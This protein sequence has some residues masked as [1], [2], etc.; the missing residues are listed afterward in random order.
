MND[1]CLK[2]FFTGILV[3]IILTCLLLFLSISLVHQEKPNST[4]IPTTPTLNQSVTPVETEKP[5]EDKRLA[6]DILTTGKTIQDIYTQ[7]SNEISEGD[8]N[9]AMLTL[10]IQYA[11]ELSGAVTRANSYHISPEG[12]VMLNSWLAYLDKLPMVLYRTQMQIENIGKN[13]YAKA[14]A[15]K[16]SADKILIVA[17]TYLKAAMD[18]AKKLNGEPAELR[19]NKVSLPLSNK[20]I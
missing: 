8:L 5:F 20:D 13:Y 12:K 4:P 6:S 18:E 1:P 7:L 11:D 2:S 16:I 15:E 9:G 17:D 14:H 3:G 19:L 10:N